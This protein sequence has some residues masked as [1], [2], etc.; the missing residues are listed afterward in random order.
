MENNPGYYPGCSLTGSSREYG[1]ST[2]KLYEALGITL[3]EIEDWVCC[4][5]TPGHSSSHLLPDA[6]ALKNLSQAKKQGIEKLITPCM[7]CYSRFKF[8]QYNVSRDPGIRE[9]L[10]EILGEK[11]DDENEIDIVHPLDNLNELV[12]LNNIKKN[13]KKIPED[14]KAVCYYGCV[15]TRPP[16]VMGV[17][18][19]ENPCQM[20]RLLDAAGIETVEWNYKTKCCGAALSISD[21]E[22]A[23]DLCKEILSDAKSRGADMIVVACPLCHVN[24]DLRQGQIERKHNLKFKIPVLYITQVIGLVLGLSVEDLGID[25]HFVDASKLL[26]EKRLM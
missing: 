21:T 22:I 12:I 19:Y 2:E 25:K 1:K 7:A 9:K 18:D 4:G 15:F 6:L 11:Y 20:E 23:L 14:L 16:E 26:K 10:E 5:A 13:I 24:L 3:Q 8:A 17:S